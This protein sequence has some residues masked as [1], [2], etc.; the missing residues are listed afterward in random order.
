MWVAKRRTENSAKSILNL[1]SKIWISNRMPKS[2]SICIYVKSIVWRE[3]K[4]F[5]RFYCWC[6]R[7][8]SSLC[9][10]IWWF[11]FIS[12]SNEEWLLCVFVN[13]TSVSHAIVLAKQ[14]IHSQR[15]REFSQ[16]KRGR[17]SILFLYFFDD[18]ETLKRIRFKQKSIICFSNIRWT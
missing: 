16:R 12:F 7:Q 17:E 9:R 15:E 8:K 10:S 13:S 6:N 18:D 11:F 3:K 1:K 14:H 5:S 4:W 2:K